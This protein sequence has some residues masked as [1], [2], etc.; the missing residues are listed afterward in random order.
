MSAYMIAFLLLIIAWVL[1]WVIFGVTSGLIHI[2]VVV[3]ALSLILI[4][5]AADT[6]KRTCALRG[7]P[8]WEIVKLD[9]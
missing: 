1:G 4:S 8:P 5:S 3:A 6:R 9:R 7:D 2:L